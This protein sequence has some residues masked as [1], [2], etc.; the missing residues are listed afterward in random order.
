MWEGGR[1]SR[2]GI[3]SSGSGATQEELLPNSTTALSLSL[4]FLARLLSLSLSR[5]SQ[6]NW[7]RKS[8]ENAGEQDRH[9]RPGGA[10]PPGHL[11]GR[12]RRVHLHAHLRLRRLRLRHGLRQAD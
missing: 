7:E 10:V 5:S 9:R 1:G 12:R 11:P 2:R 8:I 3:C 4:G 6:S